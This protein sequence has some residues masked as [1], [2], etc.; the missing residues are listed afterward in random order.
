MKQQNQ[1][2]RPTSGM[3]GS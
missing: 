2:V 1:S 3:Y